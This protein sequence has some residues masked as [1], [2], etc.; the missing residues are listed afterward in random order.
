MKRRVDTC[1]TLL[2]VVEKLV[3]FPRKRP[4]ETKEHV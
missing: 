3:N 4:Q 2:E 1:S